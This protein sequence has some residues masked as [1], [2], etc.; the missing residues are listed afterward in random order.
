MASTVIF[1]RSLVTGSTVNMTPEN[2]DCTIFWTGTAI[3][4]FMCSKPFSDAVEDG[5][6]LE[7]RSPALLD[8]LHDPVRA[9]DVEEGALLSG[10]RGLRQ[11]LRRRRAAHG[12]RRLAHRADSAA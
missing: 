6:R 9:D 1:E 4:T 2:S 11:V 3:F 7:E 10:E 5:A 8:R 12:D